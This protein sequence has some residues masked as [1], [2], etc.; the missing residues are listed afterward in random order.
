M[1][2][3]LGRRISIP[4]FVLIT[5]I[6]IVC[7]NLAMLSSAAFPYPYKRIESRGGLPAS[8]VP[9]AYRPPPAYTLRLMHATTLDLMP[10]H[11]PDSPLPNPNMALSVMSKPGSQAVPLTPR[12]LI[13]YQE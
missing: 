8:A 1:K 2:S 11:G 7:E 10:P 13:R 4:R 6:R 3:I 12:H 9:A 5:R